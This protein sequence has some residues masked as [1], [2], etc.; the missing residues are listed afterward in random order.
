VPAR[1]T[2]GLLHFVLLIDQ[3]LLNNRPRP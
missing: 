2:V 1:G 3:Q